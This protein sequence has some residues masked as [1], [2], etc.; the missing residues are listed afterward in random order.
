MNTMNTDMNDDQLMALL[1]EVLDASERVPTSAVEA[2]YAAIELRGL[3]NEMAELVFDSWRDEAM[4][5]RGPGTET[6][7]LSFA[8]DHTSIDVE[9]HADGITMVGQMTPLVDG[10]MEAELESGE[11]LAIDVDE[12]GR[13][14]L[15]APAGPMR[16]RI[17]GRLTTP[18]ITR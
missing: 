3:D 8:N 17:A 9:L 10:Q 13:F 18:W 12:F 15:V 5:M 1:T 6:R 4:V 16:L 2:A 7:L 11:V 14:R